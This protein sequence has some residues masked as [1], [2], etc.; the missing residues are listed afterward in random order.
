MTTV[1]SD[2]QALGH[3]VFI[4]RFLSRGYRLQNELLVVAERGF[5][6]LFHLTNES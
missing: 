4:T 6:P 2:G 5:S 1:K 3:K